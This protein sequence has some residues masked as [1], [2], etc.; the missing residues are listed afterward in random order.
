MM[1][2]TKVL[3]LLISGSI[4]A[5]VVGSFINAKKSESSSTEP[6]KIVAVMKKEEMIDSTVEQKLNRPYLSVRIPDHR[7]VIPVEV[8]IAEYDFFQKGDRA[9]FNASYDEPVQRLRDHKVI[10]CKRLDGP[11]P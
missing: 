4:C 6:T 10:D 5:A 2:S 7:V 3:T 1:E 11:L 8:T 9:C